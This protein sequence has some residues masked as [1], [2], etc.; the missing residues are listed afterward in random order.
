V[1]RDREGPELRLLCV[2]CHFLAAKSESYHP[3]FW[4]VVSIWYDKASICSDVTAV[5]CQFLP[6]GMC[7][8]AV[9]QRLQ[10]EQSVSSLPVLVAIPAATR[11]FVYDYQQ[12]MLHFTVT[13]RG[14]RAAWA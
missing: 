1:N 9:Q 11:V 2:G 12:A 4:G 8:R 10:C 14:S 3:G 5:E 7:I 6:A 13:S